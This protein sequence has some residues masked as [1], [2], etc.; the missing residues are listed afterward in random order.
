MKKS[1]LFVAAMFAAFTVNARVINMDLTSA[2]AIAY[3]NCS[4]TPT[5]TDGVLNVTW[6]ASSWAW[7]GVEFALDN[8]AVVNSIDFDY[9]GETP[10][11][12]SLLVYLLDSEGGKWHNN[13]ADLSMSAADWTTIADLIPVDYLWSDPG[14]TMGTYPFVALGFIANPMNESS[15]TFSLRNVILNVPDG[16]GL[17]NARSDVKAQKI[18]RDGQVLIIRDGRTFNALGAEMK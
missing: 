16:T 12:T 14:Y 3:D 15:N 13:D 5:V 1:I 7:A 8:L 4:A 9:K 11:W 2:S 17:E 6:T 10:E 18:I